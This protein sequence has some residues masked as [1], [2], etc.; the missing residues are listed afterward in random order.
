L[1]LPTTHVE[2]AC[3]KGAVPGRGNHAIFARPRRSGHMTISTRV[4][5]SL[6]LMLDASHACALQ[7][8]RSSSLS[9]WVIELF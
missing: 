4:W 8:R 9:S 3:S 7:I 1:E 5:P 6:R 2:G